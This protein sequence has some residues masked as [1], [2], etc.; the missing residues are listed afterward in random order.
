MPG[1]V[2]C[3]IRSADN[4]VERLEAAARAAKDALAAI[5]DAKGAKEAYRLERRAA[6]A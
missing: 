1:R 6:H 3:A 5:G 2:I 4:V